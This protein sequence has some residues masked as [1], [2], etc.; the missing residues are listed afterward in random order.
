MSSLKAKER[1]QEVK[2]SKQLF[3]DLRGLM[4]TELPEEV[5]E[6]T[7]LLEIDL[8][9]NKFEKLPVE[10]ARL[11]YLLHLNL[12]HNYIMEIDFGFTD[13][14]CLMSLDISHNF[15]Y[16]IPRCISYLKNAAIEFENNP[17]LVGLPAETEFYNFHEILYFLDLLK[18]EKNIHKFYETKLIFVGG[19]EVGKTTLMKVLQKPNYKVEVGKE[20]TTHG[21]NI[22]SLIYDVLFPARPPHYNNFND[23]DDVYIFNEFTSSIGYNDWDD[24]DE[25]KD[26][27]D[28]SFGRYEDEEDD[29]EEADFTSFVKDGMHYMPVAQILDGFSED[30]RSKIFLSKDLEKLYRNTVVKKEVKINLW[31]FGG[32]E[33]YHAT[34]QFFLT[35]RS[36]YV[37]VWEPRKD[38]EEEDFDYWLNTIKLLS[39]GSPVM[40]VMNK[41]DIRYKNIDKKSYKE[42]FQNIHNFFEVSCLNKQGIVE[43]KEEI[44]NCIKR[45]PHIGDKIPASWIKVREKVKA[46][47]EDYISYS[48]FI[49]ICGDENLITDKREISLFSEYMHDI[50]DV[51]HFKEDPILKN[52]VIINPQWATKAVYKLIDTI[53]VQRNNGVFDISELENY[54]D[55]KLYPMEK[56]VEIIQLMERFEICFKLVGAKNTYVIPELLKTEIPDS[57]LADEI[58]NG[59]SL[60][61]QIRYEFMPSGLITKLICRL[62]FLIYKSNYWKNGVVFMDDLAKGIVV[63]SNKMITVSISGQQKINLLAVIRNEVKSIHL[64]FNMKEGI[65]FWEEIPCSCVQCAK[66][67]PFYYS[68][69]VLK[70]FLSRGK[71]EIDC[72]LSTLTVGINELILGYNSLKPAKKLIHD[73]LSA[74]SQLQGQNK[75]I[76]GTEDA[77]NSFISERLSKNGIVAK[78]QSKWGSSSSGVAQGELD[79]KIEDGEGNIVSIFEGL[80]LKSLDTV[81]LSNH[82]EKTISNYDPNGLPEKYVGAYYGGRDFDSFTK[83]YFNYM[84]DYEIENFVFKSTTDE[85]ESL[86]QET[87]IKIFKSKYDRS[88]R[89]IFLY[90]ILINMA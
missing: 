7:F 48:T 27:D 40:I 75:I 5:L 32:Q 56:H 49:S 31:D 60:K 71:N 4:L 33:I 58:Q 52:I 62:Y 55:L 39:G 90:H 45:M 37:F 13:F 77:R 42:K 89:E 46:V 78:D 81:N 10:L 29:G 34:H 18:E 1:I 2:K 72:H 35:K 88:S 22:N 19:G 53:Q 66:G 25:D 82:I 24:E 61:F 73:I 30:E 74:A 86:I 80:N 64:D 67:K 84:K 79:I 38:N 65:D 69:S 70:K 21:I 16:S 43:L 36:I 15:L 87:E 41:L 51:I 9:Y 23:I 3:L 20:A 63:R 17:F 14:C 26:E 28:F 44:E 54:W 76:I 83:K 50:G 47:T 11:P 68:Y 57:E 12:S 59:D 85:S 8:S 6:L